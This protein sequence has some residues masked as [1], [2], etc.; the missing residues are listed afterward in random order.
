MED[1]LRLLL[2]LLLSEPEYAKACFAF[3]KDVHPSIIEAFDFRNSRGYADAMN[4]ILAFLL[5]AAA[6]KHETEDFIAI[7]AAI[8]HQLVT[9]FKNMERN[10]DVGKQDEIGKRKERDFHQ[11]I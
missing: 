4:R 3:A 7:D 5:G 10:D 6:K 8:D 11:L 9:F 1:S 2:H